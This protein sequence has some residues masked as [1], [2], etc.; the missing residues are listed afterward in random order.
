MKSKLPEANFVSKKSN[1]DVKYPAYLLL[2]MVYSGE[3]MG[4]VKAQF[5]K[6]EDDILSEVGI[7]QVS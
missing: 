1:N 3:S 4:N 6:P 5:L 2:S 7:K